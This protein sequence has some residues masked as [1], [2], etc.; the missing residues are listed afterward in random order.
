MTTRK[1]LKFARDNIIYARIEGVH[2]LTEY[3]SNPAQR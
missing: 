1:N 2:T 3:I